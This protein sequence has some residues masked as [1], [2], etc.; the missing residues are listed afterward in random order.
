MSLK[1]KVILQVL[2]GKRS[3]ELT[4]QGAISSSTMLLESYNDVFQEPKDLQP[5]K[6]KDHAIN[7]IPRTKPI[8]IRP[9]HCPYFQK[10]EI[11]RIVKE[12]LK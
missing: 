6:S 10:D 9:Y 4:K 7:L 8:S 11:E 12:L 2:E 1:K 5:S 3:I